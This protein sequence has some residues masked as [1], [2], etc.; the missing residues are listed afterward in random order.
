[1][2]EIIN[3]SWF[4][5]VVGGIISGFLVWFIT[6]N[7]FKSKQ[8]QEYVQKVLSV[9]RELIYS[10]RSGIS[11]RNLPNLDV[12]TALRSATSRKYSVDINDIYTNKEL[13]EELIKE[14]M[15]SSFIPVESKASFCDLL[16]PL[17]KEELPKEQK[18]QILEE[19][20]IRLDTKND[21]IHTMSLTLAVLVAVF[22][23]LTTVTQKMPNLSYI[24]NDKF[25][26]GIVIPT[27]TSLLATLVA[28]LALRVMVKLK[29]K[30]EQNNKITGGDYMIKSNIIISNK[31]SK[32][33]KNDKQIIDKN[34]DEAS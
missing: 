4:I 34:F 13:A 21:V 30:D 26:T 2:L 1:M 10:L 11:Q 7:L 31:M 27:L 15:D 19:Q 8:T 12:L 25:L 9:N 33:L 23:F 29:K 32:N 16:N 6:N 17:L 3:N 28:L 14:V 18:L 20:K 22:T 24:A 5:G